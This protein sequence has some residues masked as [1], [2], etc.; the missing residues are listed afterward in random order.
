MED[1]GQILREKNLKDL[2]GCC[3][4]DLKDRG[5]PGRGHIRRILKS[6]RPLLTHE[7]GHAPPSGPSVGL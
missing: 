5:A 7:E 6:T 1:A 2:K 4:S 3:S